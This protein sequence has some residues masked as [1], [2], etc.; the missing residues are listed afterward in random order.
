MKKTKK[1][2]T[3][4]KI[5]VHA[6]FLSIFLATF[7]ATL[8][9]RSYFSKSADFISYFVGAEILAAGK[10]SLLYDLPTQ[11]FFQTSVIDPKIGDWVLPFR[12]IPA[13]LLIY[14][15]LTFLSLETAYTIFSIGNFLLLIF[16]YYLLTRVFENISAKSKYLFLLVIVFIPALQALCMGQLSVL[17]TTI[18]LIIFNSIKDKKYVLAGVFSSLLIIKA[19]YLTAIPF[20]F[21]LVREKKQFLIGFFPMFAFLI[22]VSSV[23]SYPLWFLRYPA[24]LFT[25]ENSNYGSRFQDMGSFYANTRFLFSNLS[26]RFVVFLN[27]LLYFVVLIF[28]AIRSRKLTY[29]TLFVSTILFS[30]VFSVH[31]LSFDYVLL[32]IPFYIIFN[33]IFRGRKKRFKFAYFLAFVIYALPI[34][35]YTGFQAYLSFPLLT[36]GV[37][38]LIVGK[39]HIFLE[40]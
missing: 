40:A 19:Q 17:I 1:S 15:P 7:M 23:M 32:L 29:E 16:F 20:I 14:L 10:G 28:F 26:G 24:F 36:L 18:F 38:F 25:T 3:I 22:L 12:G 11:Y 35:A 6:S 33:K 34:L 37:L 31:F 27:T 9:N 5:V 4:K 21:F 8:V 2:Q 39:S 30:I 13:V